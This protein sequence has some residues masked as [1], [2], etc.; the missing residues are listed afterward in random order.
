M[1]RRAVGYVMGFI[2]G[3][4]DLYPFLD[5]KEKYTTEKPFVSRATENKGLFT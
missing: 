5:R 2:P 1:S 3:R 4:L